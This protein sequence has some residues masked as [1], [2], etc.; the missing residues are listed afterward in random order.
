MHVGDNFI[1][2]HLPKTGG[3]SIVEAL[4]KSNLL[5]Y[6]GMDVHDGRDV[7][8]DTFPIQTEKYQFTF[9]RNPFDRLVSLYY[10]IV[11][12]SWQVHKAADKRLFATIDIDFEHWFYIV[13]FGFKF[14]NEYFKVIKKHESNIH[15]DDE[16]KT[17]M[18][19]SFFHITLAAIQTQYSHFQEKINLLNYIGRYEN[20]NEDW[21]VIR[22]QINC[23]EKL[24]RLLR[25]NR[26][27]YRD[28]YSPAMQHVIKQIYYEDFKIFDYDW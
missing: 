8:P 27:H 28:Y 12:G 6:S 23:T 26:K 22:S 5:D 9:V 7:H 24:P 21:E 15:S 18:I 3:T 4:H 25:T 11:D 19:G 14:E 13:F 2:Y 17:F 16:I 1:F 20:I 10:W